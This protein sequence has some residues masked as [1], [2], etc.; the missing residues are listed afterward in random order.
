MSEASRQSDLT[1]LELIKDNIKEITANRLSTSEL[2]TAIFES[3]NDGRQEHL[4]F[5]A[6]ME[7]EIIKQ[8]S[9]IKMLMETVDE[10]SEEVG[11]L[12]GKKSSWRNSGRLD[13]Q[14]HALDIIRKRKH[15]NERR[16][17][18]EQH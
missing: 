10:L 12:S 8:E 3:I 17:Q 14:M 1:L 11:R 18:N 16:E 7:T 13:N 6:E 5:K 4:Q 2:R 9:K 15:R